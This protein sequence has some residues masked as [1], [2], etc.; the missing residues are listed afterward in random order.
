MSLEPSPHQFLVLRTSTVAAVPRRFFDDVAQDLNAVKISPKT[1]RKGFKDLGGWGLSAQEITE[2]TIEETES[3]VERLLVSGRSVV[4]EGTINTR[5]DRDKFRK[6]VAPFAMIHVVVLEIRN[7]PAGTQ[8]ILQ[9]M[10]ENDPERDT[11]VAEK[12]DFIMGEQLPG[13]E[14]PSQQK[15][16]SGGHAEPYLT[17]RGGDNVSQ[18]RRNLRYYIREERYDRLPPPKRQD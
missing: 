17:L 6:M 1:I 12:M 15:G 11:K 14:W 16:K 8:K 7:T 4:H 3:T 13:I 2:A 9:K 5:A 10:F 18:L